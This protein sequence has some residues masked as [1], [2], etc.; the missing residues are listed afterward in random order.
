MNTTTDHKAPS[1]IKQA[2]TI[3]MIEFKLITR[4]KAVLFSATAIP[5]LF[6][7]FLIM[8]RE[9][10]REAGV[11]LFGMSIVF[12]AMFTVYITV[13]TTLVT[14]RQDLFLKR[15]R[16]G[17]ASDASILV[18]VFTTP[19][20]LCVAQALVVF[21]AMLAIGVLMPA[22]WWWI[23]VAF[24]GLIIASVTVAA[25]TAGLTPNPSAAQISTLPFTFVALGSLIASPL[26][27][28][29]LM[30]LTPGGAIVTLSRLAYELPVAGSAMMSIAGLLL[31]TGLGWELAKRTMRWEPRS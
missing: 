16:S 11:A 4:S 23:L 20:V 3:A 12:F 18:G 22:A 10:T 14:R 6:A 30:D 19:V 21:A 17:E 31:W 2:V 27:D 9:A 24:V 28:H 15:L 7:G 1:A 25:G 8:Q 13:T 5:L 29:Q 26:V